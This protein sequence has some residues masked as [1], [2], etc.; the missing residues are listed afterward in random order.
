[1]CQY[2][3]W[4]ASLF[5]PNPTPYSRIDTF[6]SRGLTFYGRVRHLHLEW[7]W[8]EMS[9][10]RDWNP[11]KKPN[12]RPGRVVGLST[13]SLYLLP[14]VHSVTNITSS[15]FHFSFVAWWWKWKWEE[16]TTFTLQC[17]SCAV[18]SSQTDFHSDFLRLLLRSFRK[19]ERIPTRLFLIHI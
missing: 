9:R 7:K 18:V 5:H 3:P 16:R 14:Y 6:F 13:F 4:I 19:E 15:L 12:Q 8:L 10:D 11:A 17:S 1:M 2:L